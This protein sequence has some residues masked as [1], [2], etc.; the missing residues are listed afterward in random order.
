VSRCRI[1]APRAGRRCAV[2]GLLVSAGLWL[3][4]QAGAKS[5]TVLQLQAPVE[6]FA[7]QV[8]SL[9]LPVET[10]GSAV[11]G[12]GIQ[13]T[14]TEIHV[15]L[16]ADILFD[17][18]KADIRPSAAQALHQAADLIRSRAT[19]PVHVDGHSDAK[20]LAAYNQRLSERRA[21][22]VRLWLIQKEGLRSV[23]FL[24]AGFGA[25]RPVA[26]NTAPDGADDPAGR[27]R[28]R[29]VELVLQKR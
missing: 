15:A 3:S 28:N 29:R 13:E 27:Q 8:L 1:E 24:T 22:S 20:G 4:G 21:A 2:I 12:F 9:T 7:G 18:D 19:G 25:S 23:T 10:T 16:P 14:A 17:F 26:P 11:E 6:A 5:V